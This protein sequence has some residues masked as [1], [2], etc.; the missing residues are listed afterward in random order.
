ML[1]TYCGHSGFAFRTG[2]RLLIFD[3]LG[4]GIEAPRKEERAVAFVS[5]AH[6]DHF[7][8]C[9]RE[10]LKEDRVALVTGFDVDAG[11]IRMTPGE[12][13]EI[14]DL[15]IE[16]FGS[17]DEGVSFLVHTEEG[18]VFHAGDF[19]LW[20]WKNES[21]VAYIREATE[22]FE[23]VLDTLRGRRI[24]LAFFPTDSRMGEG[25]EEGA[26]RFIEAMKPGVFIPMHFWDHPEA[27]E[28]M[29][30]K[31]LPEGV[32]VLVMTRPGETISI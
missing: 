15:S 11:G 9:V 27:A 28:A 21:D 20:H 31:K 13:I 22:A 6:K 5:H 7:H 29:R 25:Y 30:E 14:E 4:E 23:K 17:T 19:N 10:W 3:Y 32:R 26:L 24:D 18:A 16:A 12:R 8:P 1:I 2:D